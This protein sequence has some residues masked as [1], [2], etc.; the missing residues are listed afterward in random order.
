MRI[1]H[2]RCG[3]DRHGVAGSDRCRIGDNYFPVIAK[4][5][6]SQPRFMITVCGS[7]PPGA[8]L[9]LTTTSF[10]RRSRLIQSVRYEQSA[11]ALAGSTKARAVRHGQ[12]QDP[13]GNR[14]YHRHQAQGRDE[15]CLMNGSIPESA[16]ARLPGVDLEPPHIGDRGDGGEVSRSVALRVRLAG[17][18]RR[19]LL[20]LAQEPR[21]CAAPAPTGM[22]RS[23]ALAQQARDQ[24]FVSVAPLRVRRR[25]SRRRPRFRR[26]DDRRFINAVTARL[27]VDLCVRVHRRCIARCRV[28]TEAERRQYA[29]FR[30]V[31]PVARRILDRERGTDFCRQPIELKRNEFEEVQPGASLRRGLITRVDNHFA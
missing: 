23:P 14:L 18:A 25:N 7:R 27:M 4:H 15:I 10:S 11:K 12:E 1:E 30:N 17:L 24:F 22:T 13:L 16:D 5:I 21:K 9:S 28:V 3:I 29:P 19:G 2:S 31:E 6:D 8:A 20:D 26:A